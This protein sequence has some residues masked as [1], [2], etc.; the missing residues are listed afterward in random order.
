MIGGMQHNRSP[1]AITMQRLEGTLEHTVT[2]MCPGR[3]MTK[4][5]GHVASLPPF[6]GSIIR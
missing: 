6:S 2:A 5:L 4:S 3:E 1:A